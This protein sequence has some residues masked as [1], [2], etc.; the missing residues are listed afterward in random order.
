M[1]LGSSERFK[2]ESTIAFGLR[3]PAPSIKSSRTES[4]LVKVEIDLTDC[5]EIEDQTQARPPSSNHGLRIEEQ[6]PFYERFEVQQYSS[7]GVPIPS[8]SSRPPQ[9]PTPRTPVHPHRTPASIPTP[10][11]ETGLEIVGRNV[12]K[13][14]ETIEKLK[15]IGLKSIDAQ[16]PELV[17]VGDQSAGKSSLMGAIAEINLPKGQSM[18]TKVPTNIRTSSADT[19]SCAISLQISYNFEA[20][21]TQ[22]RGQIF[23]HWSENDEIVIVP[24]M[25]IE[26]KTELEQALRCAQ[27]AI[28]NPSQDPQNF[29]PTRF[30]T[31]RA[32]T[33]VDEARFSPNVIAVSIAGPGL[34]DLSFYDL[35]GL[36]QAAEA[37]EQKYLIKVFDNLT[38]KYIKHENA[39][40]ICA[41]TMQNDPGVSKTKGFI[42]DSNADKRCIGVLTMPDRMQNDTAHHDYTRILENSA[43]VLEPHGY[44]VTKQPGP[45]S[46]ARG[47]RYHAIARDEEKHF[48]ETSKL[49][50]PGGEWNRFSHRCGTGTIQEYLSKVFARQILLSLPNISESIHKQTLEVDRGLA[51]LPDAPKDKVQHIVRQALGTFSSQVRQFMDPGSASSFQ[52]EWNKLC[53]QFLKTL[54][55]MRPGCLCK[56][57]E[58]KVID[59]DASDDDDVVEISHRSNVKRGLDNADIRASE[60]PNKKPRAVNSTP[61]SQQ[62]MHAPAARGAKPEP[63]SSS[64]RLRAIPLPSMMRKFSKDEMGPFHQ[65]YLNAGTGAMTLM[66]LRTA[67]ANNACAGRPT[68]TNFKVKQDISLAAIVSWEEPLATFI[69]CAFKKVREEVMTTLETSLAKY[70]RTSLFAEARVIVEAFLDLKEKEQRGHTLRYFDVEKSR[71]FT[72]CLKE[73][74]RHKAE[75]LEL[76]TANRQ[77]HRIDAYVAKQ[78]HSTG[79]VKEESRARAEAE[80][81]LGPDSF[82][83]ELRAAAYVRGY[84]ATARVRFIDSVCADINAHYFFTIS[85]QIQYLL[86]GQLGLDEGDSEMKCQALVEDNAEISRQ[87]NALLKRKQQLAEFSAILDQLQ[88]DINKSGGEDHPIDVHERLVRNGFGGSSS[89]SSHD[90]MYLDEEASSTTTIP[91]SKQSG[92]GRAG[93]RY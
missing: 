14:V 58:A 32:S 35:P 22:K 45:N 77:K 29:L 20:H 36:F 28:L 4:P 19:W 76:L 21:K 2:R 67:I 11:M 74:E 56:A 70:T 18:C 78:I 81:N 5:D 37:D 68:E 60:S 3:T 50:G 25:E 27:T 40:I 9:T 15:R 88:A 91:P 30:G 16:L 63:Q 43:Y 7:P 8:R 51:S 6:D 17:L 12:K 55:I 79:K 54:D 69:N 53:G 66:E 47:P 52:S 87:R 57:D 93:G 48:F 71:L 26:D 61:E 10:R 83:E 44:F 46:L 85:E 42:E 39:L 38:A 73:F 1:T 33:Q 41:I 92:K 31:P 49:W 89:T 84:Y 82:I 80:A 75:A 34:P 62:S 72:V 23:P 59:F 65:P 64:R 13:L 24:F 90:D 86:E